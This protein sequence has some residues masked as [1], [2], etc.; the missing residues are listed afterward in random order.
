MEA[1]Y[2][3]QGAL[4]PAYHSSYWLGLVADQQWPNF[5]WLDASLASPGPSSW[6]H[7]SVY[8]APDDRQPFTANCSGEPLGFKLCICLFNLQVYSTISGIAA[9]SMAL[10]KLRNIPYVNHKIIHQVP[11]IHGRH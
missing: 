7:W 3:A 10:H 9:L 4:M 11:I 8:G 5:R 6:S 1:Y 2:L